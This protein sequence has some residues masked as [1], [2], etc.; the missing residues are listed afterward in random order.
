METQK[1]SDILKIQGS[2]KE[3]G[4]KKG[5]RRKTT[6]CTKIVEYFV[7]DCLNFASL[8]CSFY[9]NFNNLFS[10][11]C[12][13]LR[14]VCSEISSWYVEK[15]DKRFQIYLL[16]YLLTYCS[17]RCSLVYTNLFRFMRATNSE[18][19]NFFVFNHPVFLYLFL[20][21]CLL[22]LNDTYIDCLMKVFYTSN[23]SVTQ[24]RTKT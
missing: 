4:L 3:P 2:S 10:R 7:Y 20:L 12:K 15:M 1:I 14:K 6:N 16:I 13:V 24:F 9:E 18:T 23:D 11:T 17:V 19:V 21:I 22:I 8:Y 5:E